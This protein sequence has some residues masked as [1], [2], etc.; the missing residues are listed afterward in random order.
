ME[1]TISI[2]DNLIS[3][4][5]T[6]FLLVSALLYIII[7]Q[8]KANAIKNNDSNNS[9]NNNNNSNSNTDNN[10]CMKTQNL[11]KN[12]EN[13]SGIITD[14]I[15]NNFDNNNTNNNNKNYLN[16]NNYNNFENSEKKNKLIK[17]E[18]NG[19]IISNNNNSS[20]NNNNNNS[21]PLSLYSKKE[22][23][24]LPS[25]QEDSNYHYNNNIKNNNKFNNKPNLKV[26]LNNSNNNTKRL[27]S[28]STS[29]SSSD[30]EPIPISPVSNSFLSPL[31]FTT[32]KKK[33][34]KN[35]FYYVSTYYSSCDLPNK[36]MDE[37]E[38]EEDNFN[39]Y[40]NKNSNNSTN[41]YN[42]N[43]QNKSNLSS[44]DDGYSNLLK[45]ENKNSDLLNKGFQYKRKNS[46]HPP[47]QAQQQPP[48][49]LLLE[50]EPSFKALEPN[51]Q[52]LTNT[53]PISS[54][55]PTTLSSINNNLESSSNLLKST[56]LNKPPK[57]SISKSLDD[58][59]HEDHP[60]QISSPI[61]SCIKKLKKKKCILPQVLQ[62]KWRVKPKKVLIIKKYNDETINELIP[63]LVGWLKDIGI[64]VM[65]ESDSNEENLSIND[66]PMIEVLSSSA[67]P[68]SIDFI[69]SMGGDG[70]IL[71]TSSLFK[72]YI[73]PILSFS[74]GSL[75]FLTAFDYSH[76]REYIQSVIDGK[77]FVSYRLRL[78]C[79]VVTSDGNVTTTTIS[80]P[81]TTTTTT[82]T[83]NPTPDSTTTNTPSGGSASAGSGTG[84]GL[85]NIGSNINR[86]RY[87]VLN[88]VTIDRG[89]N[90]Y[91]SNLECCCDGKLITIV[92][93]DGLIIATST[94]STAYS[95]SA[96]GSLV[97]P[98]IPAILITPICPHTLSF[99]PVILPST[100]ELIIRVPETSRCPVWASF[101]GKNRQELKRGDYVIIK[102]SRWAVPVVCKTDESNE[103]FEKLAQNLNWNLR[104]VQKSFTAPHGGS[105]SSGSSSENSNNSSP[106][107]LSTSS[108]NSNPTSPPI[109][110]TTKTSL[111]LSK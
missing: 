96:G 44:D 53:P 22:L 62:L 92:Q 20:N 102:T 98:T 1:I 2:P 64:K 69:I 83:K 105:I 19:D 93:A 88:E 34:K 79:T 99:R 43:N 30:E 48:N 111:N 50:D 4:Y 66:D 90:P 51:P 110:S 54:T 60:N 28:T 35:Q 12:S 81:T 103:W 80:T 109:P 65:K 70:T 27:V 45:Q 41:K 58:F 23:I 75:G 57:N 82:T 39:N 52:S 63:S 47:Q 6:F 67:D 36:V 59:P 86:H 37:N 108:Q 8:K 18:I 95:L 94:G 76:H 10:L 7:T 101:D 38:I 61:E 73:P 91:L 106:L 104:Q 24:P 3:H 42:H 32:G 5:L 29:S 55:T 49:Q 16:K 33:S 107:N 85:I 87:Q 9:N 56:N 25:I 100:S 84:S 31:N 14:S 46:K 21:S 72:T 26:T 68:Y 11:N 17:N 97:H 15:N 78:S 77:C 74:L 71:H 89:T 13:N 40:N